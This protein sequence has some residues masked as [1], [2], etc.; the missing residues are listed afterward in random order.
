MLLNTCSLEA[1]EKY[2]KFCDFIKLESNNISKFNTFLS[3]N[4]SCGSNL[5]SI[6]ERVELK[7]VID[8]RYA[9]NFFGV[10][11]N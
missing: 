10:E 8:R 9:Y 2:L 7:A 4:S 6:E 11:F 5:N 1:T 3:N